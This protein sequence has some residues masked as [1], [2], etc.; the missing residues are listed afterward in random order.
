MLARIKSSKY[1]KI[2]F[3]QL[4]PWKSVDLREAKLCEFSFRFSAK[5]D[6]FQFSWPG[7]R[8]GAVSVTILLSLVLLLLLMTVQHFGTS[9][10][11]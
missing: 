2:Q 5:G 1:K 8:C 10:R 3:K 7:L 6:S 11:P 4:L 9:K